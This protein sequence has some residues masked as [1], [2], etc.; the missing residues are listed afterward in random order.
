MRLLYYCISIRIDT[1]Y[2]DAG[3]CYLQLGVVVCIIFIIVVWNKIED[4]KTISFIVNFILY[5]IV[6]ILRNFYMFCYQSEECVVL[7]YYYHYIESCHTRQVVFIYAEII[8]I[9]FLAL[10]VKP[11]TTHG[12]SRSNL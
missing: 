9:I 1:E 11:I 6:G 10:I 7:Y 12:R 5:T 3:N 4:A 2:F 8:P